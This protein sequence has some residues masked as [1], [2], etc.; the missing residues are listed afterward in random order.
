M[1]GPDLLVRLVA[2]KWLVIL[3]VACAWDPLIASREL[4]KQAKYQDLAADLARQN[5]GFTV[6]VVPVVI[7]D[8]GTVGQL[9]QHLRGSQLFD[10]TETDGLTRVIQREVL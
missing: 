5:P 8:L 7:G 2:E 10:E 9:R 4:E 1:S 6:R 3:E